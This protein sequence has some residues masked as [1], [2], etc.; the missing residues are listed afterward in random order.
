V[1]LVSEGSLADCIVRACASATSIRALL[2]TD[3][4]DAERVTDCLA[5]ALATEAAAAHTGSVDVDGA[6]L[7]CADARLAGIADLLHVAA[8][9]CVAPSQC[10]QQRSCTRELAASTTI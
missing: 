10:Q 9:L 3:E 5:G 2:S 6:V 4:C 7:V 8:A 1:G